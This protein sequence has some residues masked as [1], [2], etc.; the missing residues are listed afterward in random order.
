MKTFLETVRSFARPYLA[1]YWPRFLIGILLGLLF[2]F[3]NALIL[4][5]VLHHR[6]ACR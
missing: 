5:G 2:G 6:P 3:S 4:G 1:R